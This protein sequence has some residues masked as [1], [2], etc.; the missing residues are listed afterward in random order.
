MVGRICRKGKHKMLQY[1][2]LTSF[3]PN[4]VLPWSVAQASYRL[5]QKTFLRVDNFAKVMSRKAC[6]MLKDS[7]FL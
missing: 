5:G 2:V 7:E 1:E 3:L 4:F 6:D